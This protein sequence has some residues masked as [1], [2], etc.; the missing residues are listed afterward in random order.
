MLENGIAIPHGM[1]AEVNKIGLVILTL[2]DQSNGQIIG[3]I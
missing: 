3:W 2:K 1:P